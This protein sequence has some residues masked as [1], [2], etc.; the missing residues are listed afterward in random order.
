MNQDDVMVPMGE[1]AQTR[2]NSLSDEDKI[3]HNSASKSGFGR[4]VENWID[5]KKAY[6]TNVLEFATVCYNRGHSAAFP[7]ELPEWFIKLFSN[8]G[9]LVLDPFIGSGT[10]AIVALRLQR[11]YLG[12]E[13][14]KKYYD[15]TKI[16]L[17]IENI[18]SKKLKK[19]IMDI[20]KT[21]SRTEDWK[22]SI[23]EYKKLMSRK[24]S[25]LEHFNK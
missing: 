7:E 13:K 3:R 14:Q 20:I 1:W 25:A 8:P 24:N 21:A 22:K 12:V 15:L 16:Y 11:H 19:Q 2:F 10:T 23:L 4:K 5:R 6:P 17:E 9:D 18:R